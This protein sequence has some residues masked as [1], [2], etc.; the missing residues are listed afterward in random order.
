MRQAQYREDSRRGEGKR[1]RCLIAERLR[2]RAKASVRHLG[3]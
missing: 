2:R 1:S 3:R